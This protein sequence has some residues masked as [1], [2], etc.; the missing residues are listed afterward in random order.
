MGHY[1]NELGTGM[2]TTRYDEIASSFKYWNYHLSCTVIKNK[3]QPSSSRLKKHTHFSTVQGPP[4]FWNSS[5]FS[6]HMT[7]TPKDDNE[8]GPQLKGS[9]G[10]PRSVFGKSWMPSMP[11]DDPKMEQR[12]RRGLFSFAFFTVSM[13]AGLVYGWPSLR[14]NLVNA[15]GSTI[16]EK[17]LGLIFTLSSWS[18]QGGR[19]LFGLARDHC[20]GT[21]L[22]ATLSL[23]CTTIGCLGIALTDAESGTIIAVRFGFVRDNRLCAFIFSASRFVDAFHNMITDFNVPCRTWIWKSTLSSTCGQ[24]I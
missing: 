8:I 15:E 7:T 1:E 14:R 9:S 4:C 13:S 21:Q 10:A 16:D 19:F 6:I 3:N 17:T 5:L 12:R 24:P 23:L 18:T 11:S 20:L 2:T 22:A